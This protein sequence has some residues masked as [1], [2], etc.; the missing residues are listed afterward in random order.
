MKTMKK[1]IF[2]LALMFTLAI[3]LV[4]CGKSKYVVTFYDGD[5]VYTTTNVESGDTVSKPSNPNKDNMKFEN[6][7]TDKEC[8][9]VY[10][11]EK[12]VTENL[13]LYAKFNMI[14][15]VISF[16][17]N[18]GNVIEAKTVDSG[19]TV[20][21]PT[22]VKDRYEFLGWYTDE[23]LTTEFATT[24]K[25]TS[26]MTLYAK[27][28]EKYFKILFNPDNDTAAFEQT[29]EEK[30]LAIKP[31][32]PEKIGYAFV[33][34]VKENGEAYDFNAIVTSNMNLKASYIKDDED[35]Y[36]VS[37]E[38]NGGTTIPA[39]VA[40]M[41]STISLPL[42]IKENYILAGWY[43]DQEF[44][45]EFTSTTAVNSNITLYAKWKEP[46]ANQFFKVT[47][48]PN[49]DASAF[50]E[51]VEANTCAIRPINPTKEG[52]I[53]L[54]WIDEDGM[55]F[56]FNNPVTKDVTLKASYVEDDKTQFVVSFEANGGSTISSMAVTPGAT[57]S[58][59]LSIK[60]GYILSGWYTDEK[61]ENEF[62][63][64]SPVNKNITLYAKWRYP[65]PDETF[66]RV[67][68]DPDNG[69]PSFTET[70]EP[71]KNAI[72][73]INPAKD[74]YTFVNWL[75]EDG[76]VFN[77]NTQINEDI[78]LKASYVLVDDTKYV[79]SFESNGGSSVSAMVIVPG[80]TITLP[81]S[82]KENYILEGWF[83]DKSFENEFTN[84]TI[85]DKNLTLYAKWKYVPENS[86]FTI[87][88][89]PA[90]GEELFAETVEKN[91][92]AVKP[93]DPEKEGYTFVY[94][95]N[96]NKPFSF[97]ELITSDL[98]LVAKWRE[99]EAE[100][101]VYIVSFAC[102]GGSEINNVEVKDGEL[103]IMPEPPYYEGYQFAGWYTDLDLT[104]PFDESKPIKSDLTLFASWSLI[105]GTKYNVTFYDNDGTVLRVKLAEGVYVY[106]QEVAEGADAIP[107][108]DPQ[109]DGYRFDGWNTAFNNVQS[110]LEVKAT[111]VRAFNVYFYDYNRTLLKNELVDFGNSATEPEVPERYG[112][113]FTG[114]DKEFNYIT[115]DI[116]IQTT[117]IK[118]YEI[119][120]RDYNGEL[121]SR[122]WYDEG[123]QI[124]APDVPEVT[125][126]DKEFNGWD[127][128]F[129][130]AEKDVTIRMTLRTKI[131]TVR[132]IDIDNTVLS[133]E[134][135]YIGEAAIAPTM[136]DKIYIDWKGTEKAAYRFNSW[137][138]EFNN[139]TADLDVIANYDKI[140][141]PLIYVD[142]TKVSQGQE[143][144]EVSVYLIYD[145]SFEAMHLNLQ[146]SDDIEMK[147]SSIALKGQFN[148]GSQSNVTLDP[149]TKTCSFNCIDTRGFDLNGNY[150][151]IMRITIELDKYS[152]V[153]LYPISV[154]DGSYLT[155]NGVVKI[156][157]IVIN[158]GIVI[159]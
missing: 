113:R 21:L 36:I 144:V 81:L 10:D 101:K 78:I 52:F 148:R 155:N 106:T 146:Y 39:K 63:G 20:T 58:L 90:N 47:F 11:F 29:V 14:T 77:F 53:F 112:Y 32:N 5:N 117:Y 64:L 88:F 25:I 44:T 54:E 65:V 104:E 139:I 6:W 100:E 51:N 55:V 86:Y 19:S 34:W 102:F 18:G 125:I 82:V 24:T 85:V 138:K 124:V 109:K 118:Q 159:E 1:F 68:F 79:V 114:W 75:K 103:I 152:T 26:N 94:W 35:Y 46:E 96:N 41:G 83:T 136:T 128:E 135:I 3:T 110:D 151:E 108:A 129:D 132:F 131:Y 13:S 142:T 2:V 141:D 37:F 56:D 30:T 122:T 76:T 22:P 9:L 147:E 48:N 140:T 127:Q 59:P 157:P 153:G 49:N 91:K 133:Q 33:N 50:V 16:N 126:E 62:T 120:F 60:D 93:K 89:D 28:H 7:Y 69:N 158:G 73:P 123:A 70:I 12:P 87:S 80:E 130:K 149:H 67:T 42:T 115:Q 105:E 57:I 95:A 23:K 99:D 15:Y 134:L 121:I 61:F 97:N 98:N 150:S 154:I 116:I 84:K 119:K 43:T 137:D 38:T 156:L 74:G 4:A 31:A 107:P 66:Y 92:K 72:R 27:W 45:N 8:T 145:G 17:T 111:Y 40:F 143:K 71:G